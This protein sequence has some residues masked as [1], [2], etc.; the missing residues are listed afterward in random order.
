MENKGENGGN[1]NEEM[2][3]DQIDFAFI[4]GEQK[5]DK[6]S[7]ANR[8]SYQELEAD[9]LAKCMRDFVDKKYQNSQNFKTTESKMQYPP[10]ETTLPKPQP[11][12]DP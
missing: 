2:N 5:E 1:S 8:K 4:I 11:H 9:G 6:V 7:G 12:P 3:Q 10:Y